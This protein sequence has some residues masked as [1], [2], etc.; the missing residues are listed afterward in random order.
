MPYQ[1]KAKRE[2]SQ[3]MTLREAVNHVQAVECSDEAGAL[4]Q[5]RMALGDGDIPA[6]WAAEPLP[7]GFYSVGDPSPFSSDQVPTDALYWHSVL[8]FLEGDCRVIDQQRYDDEAQRP[9]LPRPRPLLLLRSRVVELWPLQDQVRKDSSQT[10][11]ASTTQPELPVHRPASTDDI[12]RAA[13]ELYQR[14]G[15]P[16]NQTKAEQLL[17]RMFPGTSRKEFIRPILQRQEFDDLRLKPGN[18]R[19]V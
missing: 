7:P 1:S 13:R 10:D 2:R 18:Q 8:I 12:L 5:L 11:S 3:W 17:G 14:P 9:P 4:K 16:P 15:K 6:H 19:K